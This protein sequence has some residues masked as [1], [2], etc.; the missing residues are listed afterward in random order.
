VLFP[1]LPLVRLNLWRRNR[2]RT[3]LT[4][5]AVLAATIVFS[6]VMVV[7]FAMNSI[8]KSADGVPRLAVTNRTSL[9]QGL[10]DSYYSKVA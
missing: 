4:I 5:A 7:P 3:L 6:V 8:V 9:G 1:L 2:R 10:P